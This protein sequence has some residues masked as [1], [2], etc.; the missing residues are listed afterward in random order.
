MNAPVIVRF[1]IGLCLAAAI[2][3]PHAAAIAGDTQALTAGTVLDAVLRLKPGEY[4]WAPQVAPS[5]P[6]LLVVNVTTQ[7]AV[8]YRNGVPIGVTT[9]STGRRGHLTPLGVFPILQKQ[10]EHYSSIYDNAPMP[11][12]QRLTWGGVALHGGSLPGYPASHGCIRLPLEFAR[13]L[14]AETRLGMTVMVMQS[15]RPHV[16]SPDI[17]PLPAAA[18]TSPPYIWAPERSPSGPMVLVLS[19]ADHQLVVLR[20]GRQIGAAPADVDGQVDQPLLSV[21]QTAGADGAHWSRVAL[22][23]QDV[24]GAPALGLQDIH[25]DDSF[26]AS[27]AAVIE[28]GTTLVITGDS[29]VPAADEGSKPSGSK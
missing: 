3:Q 11:F 8:L 24:T 4:L 25:A 27:V 21:L 18:V 19:T 13:L 20:N 1:L 5:G 6:L 28:P 14:F 10:V 7:R 16:L 2:A 9:V 12:M 17:D 22:P 23:G 26:R 15:A 29:L